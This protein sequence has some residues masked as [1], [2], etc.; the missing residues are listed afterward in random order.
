MLTVLANSTKTMNYGIKLAISF[1]YLPVPMYFDITST[2]CT[3]YIIVQYIVYSEYIFCVPKMRIPLQALSLNTA[4][5]YSVFIALFVCVPGM[6]IPCRRWVSTPAP[7]STSRTAAFR[8][9]GRRSSWPSMPAR[10]LPTSGSTGISAVHTIE[11]HV[12]SN[13]NGIGD[14]WCVGPTLLIRAVDPH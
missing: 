11:W 12:R 2:Y 6:R 10:C 7:C 9:A 5:L 3:W 4:L 1:N 8:S 14:R 13:L